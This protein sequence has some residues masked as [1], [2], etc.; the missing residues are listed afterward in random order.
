MV[1]DTLTGSVARVLPAGTPSPDWRSLYRVSAAALDVLDP[2]TGRTV[3]NHPAP[4]WARAVRTSADGR[5]LVLAPDGPGG[6]FQ[7]QDAAW[8][9]A[10]V[11]VALTGAFTFDAI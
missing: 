2:L 11:D 3:A 1:V 6:H 4:V 8:T 9:A 5:W 10:P 7:V